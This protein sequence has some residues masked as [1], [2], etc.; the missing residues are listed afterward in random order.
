MLPVNSQSSHL[1]PAFRLSRLYMYFSGV[2]GKL[3]GRLYLSDFVFQQSKPLLTAIKI[4][5]CL[6]SC[7]RNEREKKCTLTLVHFQSLHHRPGQTTRPGFRRRAPVFWKGPFRL[8]QAYHLLLL[9]QCKG[10]LNQ[11]HSQYLYCGSK[12]EFLEMC[13][14]QLNEQGGKKNGARRFMERQ[15]TCPMDVVALNQSWQHFCSTSSA[16]VMVAL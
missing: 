2:A 14:A 13:F 6:I 12:C 9:L 3:K 1:T 16:L 15:C 5:A 4:K 11:V 10:T 8:F 7:N